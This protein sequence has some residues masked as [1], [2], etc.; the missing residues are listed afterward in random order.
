[1]GALLFRL[2]LTVITAEAIIDTAGEFRLLMLGKD[3]TRI[4]EVD[5]QSVKAYVKVVG[6]PNATPIELN[7]VRRK[8]ILQTRHHSSSGSCRI[9]H[10]G[11]Q[12]DVIEDVCVRVGEFAGESVR[13]GF[14]TKTIRDP[15][16]RY[17]VQH[18][19]Q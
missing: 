9:S 8:A 2:V 6:D 11:R 3:E 12:L 1:M 7:A 5:V 13:I 4:Q 19:G 10:R 16:R 17:A 15:R 14:T 18:T